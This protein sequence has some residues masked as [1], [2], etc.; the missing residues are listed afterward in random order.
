M[1]KTS[2]SL[3]ASC[4]IFNRRTF[5]VDRAV[6]VESEQYRELISLIGIDIVREA[7]VVDAA[8]DAE[9]R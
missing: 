2:R 8:V 9:A 7:S 1:P 6:C 3:V 5:I 4:K